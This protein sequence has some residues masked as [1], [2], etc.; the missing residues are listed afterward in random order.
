P[1]TGSESGDDEGLVGLCDLPADAEQEHERSDD[2]ENDDEQDDERFAHGGVYSL[3]VLVGATST[4]RP[5]R[6][7]VTSTWVCLRIVASPSAARARKRSVPCRTSTSTSPRCPGV[8]SAVTRPT[9][10]TISIAIAGSLL[11]SRSTN[12][13]RPARACRTQG[14]SERCHRPVI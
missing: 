3:R 8:M 5:P 7:A 11:P 14:S 1:L 12:G 13:R 6:L 4:V 2:R 9:F 10:P